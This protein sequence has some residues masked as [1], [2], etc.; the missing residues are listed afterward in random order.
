MR[1]RPRSVLAV[2][3][4]LWLAGLVRATPCSAHPAAA[5][6]LPLVWVLSTGGTISGKGL[7]STSLAEY[8]AGALLGEELVS[9]VPEIKQVATIKVEQIANVSS[10][11]ITIANWLTLAD[12]INAI[13]ANDRKVAGVV[14]THRSEE[15]RVG[16]EGRSRWSPYH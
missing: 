3:A 10:P 9:A 15:R 7:T 2:S 13:F 11:D 12:R 6:D 16:K 14:I 4:V 5:G 8:N 1:L